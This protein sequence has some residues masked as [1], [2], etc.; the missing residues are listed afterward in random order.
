MSNI[1]KVKPEVTIELGGKVRK[2]SFTLGALSS[3]EKELGVNTLGNDFWKN[4]SARGIVV[5][6]WAALR[7]NDPS[8]NID[9]VGDMIDMSDLEP[10]MEKLKEA[11]STAMPDTKGKGSGKSEGK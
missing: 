9:D 7:K 3:I 4:L 8:L 2:I 10:I 6:L 1:D 11:L 5:M